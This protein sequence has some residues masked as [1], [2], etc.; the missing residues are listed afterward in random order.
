MF[1]VF[2]QQRFE[3]VVLVDGALTVSVL[4]AKFKGFEF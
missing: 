1:H 4:E 2:F 3:I